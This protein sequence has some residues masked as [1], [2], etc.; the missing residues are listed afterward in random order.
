MIQGYRTYDFTTMAD[1]LKITQSATMTSLCDKYM[2]SEV[3]QPGKEEA[4]SMMLE[5]KDDLFPTGRFM[6]LLYPY[7]VMN[8]NLKHITE[9]RIVQASCEDNKCQ[10]VGILATVKFPALRGFHTEVYHAG[11]DSSY[12]IQHILSSMLYFSKMS[13]Q[14]RVVLT[15]FYPLQDSDAVAQLTEQLQLKKG[16]GWKRNSSGVHCFTIC[17]MTVHPIHSSASGNPNKMYRTLKHDI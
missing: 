1:L 8:G 4:I 14:G 7:K 12:T 17:E 3:G 10:A 16:P 6:S 15:V 5:N 9:K 13:Y 11:N 2:V